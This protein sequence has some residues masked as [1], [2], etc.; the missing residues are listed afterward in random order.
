[1]AV[2]VMALVQLCCGAGT[3]EFYR[4]QLHYSSMPTREKK[5]AG[6]TKKKKKKSTITPRH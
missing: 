4:H 2:S 1:M 3:P 5:N 6:S